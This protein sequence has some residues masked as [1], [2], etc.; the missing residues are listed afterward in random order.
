MESCAGTLLAT[1][2]R[3]CIVA[4]EELLGGF[5]ELRNSMFLDSDLFSTNFRNLIKKVVSN[6]TGLG[7]VF[8]GTAE[9]SS[10][11]KK[12]S[13]G[14]LFISAKQPLE[15]DGWSHCRYCSWK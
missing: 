7:V 12:E 9:I 5:L 4:S 13:P 2:A 10:G 11:T 14:P 8:P 3:R 1:D 15:M 6:G